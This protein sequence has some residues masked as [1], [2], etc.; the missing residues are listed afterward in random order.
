MAA[1]R[2]PRRRPGSRAG[3]RHRLRRGAASFPDAAGPGRRPRDGGHVP[4][5]AL[6]YRLIPDHGRQGDVKTERWRPHCQPAGKVVQVRTYHTTPHHKEVKIIMSHET[7]GNATARGP[8]PIAERATPAGGEIR[9]QF[10]II[11]HTSWAAAAV[12]RSG[13]FPGRPVFVAA[14]PAQPSNH[15]R[16]NNKR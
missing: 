15:N 4:G 11:H 8:P 9:P 10:T 13:T 2:H 1:K 3:Q 14:D 12:G 7:A 5:L 6:R 16:K